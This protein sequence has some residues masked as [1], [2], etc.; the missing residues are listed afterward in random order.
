M[1]WPES[2]KKALY[3]AAPGIKRGFLAMSD[4]LAADPLALRRYFSGSGAG[5][6]HC[7]MRPVLPFDLAIA[8]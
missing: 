2:E 1:K 6:R 7:T 8:A 5:G 3:H 4:L